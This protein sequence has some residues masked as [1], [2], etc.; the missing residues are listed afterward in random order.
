LPVPHRPQELGTPLQEASEPAPLALEANTESFF[1]SLV[2][3]QSGQG[4]PSQLLER[5]RISLSFL[6][7][8]Q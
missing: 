5:T 1:E 8:S 3:P 6:H 2:E 4:V 7:F